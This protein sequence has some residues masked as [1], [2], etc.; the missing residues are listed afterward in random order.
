MPLCR[1]LVSSKNSQSRRRPAETRRRPQ[2][3]PR[4]VWRSCR[5]AVPGPSWDAT[6]SHHLENAFERTQDIGPWTPMAG[7]G[8]ITGETQMTIH[9]SSIGHSKWVVFDKV[10]AYIN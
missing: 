8:P 6:L 2:S 4:R 3:R 10:M 1:I 9:N 7:Q 5:V